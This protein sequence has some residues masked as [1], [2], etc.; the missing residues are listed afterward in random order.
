MASEGKIRKENPVIAVPA[1]SR[2]IVVVRAL[3][4][5]ASSKL[6]FRLSSCS[7][8]VASRRTW[9]GVARWGMSKRRMSGTAHRRHCQVELF[10]LLDSE[11]LRSAP[12]RSERGVADH[13]VL[14][15]AF[16]LLALL[17]LEVTFHRKDQVEARRGR[18]LLDGDGTVEELRQGSGAATPSRRHRSSSLRPTRLWWFLNLPP[19]SRC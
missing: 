15:L 12:I 6:C 9:A 1:A 8:A 3:S 14:P 17:V 7:D 13:H 5:G 11:L 16:D 4:K 2:G 10:G 18:R 19:V